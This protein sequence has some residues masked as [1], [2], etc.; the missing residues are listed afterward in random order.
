MT[1][2]LVKTKPSVI[3]I[4]DLNVIGMMKNHH[5]AR[6]IAEMQWGES[7]QQLMYKTQR[8]N[9][10]LRIAP[11]FYASS[12]TCNHCKAVNKDLRLSDRVFI[13]PVCSYKIDRDFNASLN[14]RDCKIYEIA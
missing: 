10:E 7:R 3:V 6:A 11:R 9:I 2:D 5:L 4:E 8:N 1:S 14:L 13:C 12:K